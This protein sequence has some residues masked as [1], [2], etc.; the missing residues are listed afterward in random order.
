M[1]ASISGLR[2]ESFLGKPALQ[3]EEQIPQ[4]CGEARML[5]GCGGARHLQA[6]ILQIVHALTQGAGMAQQVQSGNK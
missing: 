3:D 1:P 5:G 2:V 6:Q 4:R